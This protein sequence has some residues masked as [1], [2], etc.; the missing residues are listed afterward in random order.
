MTVEDAVSTD[1]KPAAP[2]EGVVTDEDWNA[3]EQ[4]ALSLWPDPAAR[5]I[6]AIAQAIADTRARAEA[7]G[8]QHAQTFATEMLQD[9]QRIAELEAELRRAREFRD[10]PVL[11]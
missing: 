9:K 4:V 10:S 7:E 5:V 3:A 11:P 6:R 2:G 1:A 8:K